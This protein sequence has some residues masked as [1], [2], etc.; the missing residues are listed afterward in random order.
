MRRALLAAV[1][2]VLVAPGSPAAAE[3][4][5]WP[6]GPLAASG[7]WM[8]DAQGRAVV[9]R[10]F[11]ILDKQPPYL[12][13]G[14]G[15]DGDDATFLA[16]QGFSS[17]R[18][19]FMW[20]AMEPKPG[21]YDDRYL[22]AIAQTVGQLAHRRI[23]TT[24]EVNQGNWSAAL[25]GQGAPAWATLTDGLPSV[26]EGFGPSLAANPALLRAWDNFWANAPGP[27]GVGLQDRFAAMW[28]H[29]AARFAGDPWVQGFD[30]INEPWPG[31]Q[32]A[33]C[34]NPVGCPAW[35][36]WSLRPFYDRVIAAIRKVDAA[37]LV[38]Y[39]PNPLFNAGGGAT[40][41]GVSPADHRLV[42]EYHL[43]C[44]LDG[45]GAGL[46]R[47]PP[48]PPREAGCGAQ[49]DLVVRNSDAAGA[50]DGRPVLDGA[51]GGTQDTATIRREATRLDQSMQSWQFWSWCCRNDGADG[52]DIIS[53]S[54]KP[55]AGAN[56]DQAR[57]REVARPYPLATAGTPK[58]FAWDPDRHV[59]T[60]AYAATKPGGRHPSGAQTLVMLPRLQFPHGYD[61]RAIGARVTSS[62]GAQ[63][64]TL[65]RLR[66]AASV[67]L[68]VRGR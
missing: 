30:V 60:F 13:S 17:V 15:F 16:D 62:A 27:G 38:V 2:A 24:L 61:V 46:P 43:F 47:L 37:H 32:Y 52:P 64:L 48:S 3:R 63:R 7:S 1:V 12:M 4:V 8:T 25:G 59:F 34:V 14:I 56:I 51:W 50:R 10:G 21:V 29:V 22:D 5:Q 57:L 36:Q 6:R 65:R 39:Q 66:G 45:A 55:P 35:E 67:T 58:R 19:G 54:H 41:N 44:D 53:D 42:F 23:F 49:E 26:D 9:L 18:I 11:H 68:E 31:S 33:S 28:A 20:S 40:L